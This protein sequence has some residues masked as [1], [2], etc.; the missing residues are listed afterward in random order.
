MTIKTSWDS[1]WESWIRWLAIGCLIVGIGLRFWQLDRSVFWYDEVATAIR[2]S[3]HRLEAFMAQ[4]F[5]GQLVSLADLAT[6]WQSDGMSWHDTWQALTSHPEHPPLYFLLTRWWMDCFGSSANSLRSLAA[7]LSLGLFPGIYWLGWELSRSRLVGWLAIALVSLSPI[8][9]LYAR[10]ARQYSLWTVLVVLSGAA[11]LRALRLSDRDQ[12]DQRSQ[13]PKP[14][15]RLTSIQRIQTWWAVW[16]PAWWPYVLTLTLSFYT[17]LLT[18]FVAIAHGG[19]ALFLDVILFDRARPGRRVGSIVLSGAIATM[20]FI[21]WLIVLITGWEAARDFTS[22][23]TDYKEPRKQV[24]Q[25][26]ADQIARGFIQLVPDRPPELAWPSLLVTSLAVLVLGL[27]VWRCSLRVWGFVL[28]LA[29]VASGCLV[30]PDAI[31]GA[32]RTLAT[33]Y[34]MPTFLGLQVAIALLLGQA[35]AG[36]RDWR[37][38]GLV[39]VVALLTIG[40][41]TSARLSQAPSLWMTKMISTGLPPIAER[42]NQSP[43]PVIIADA[44][45]YHAG[46]TAALAR[47]LRPP[48]Q[49]YLVPDFDRLSP[50]AVAQMAAQVTDRQHRFSD[51]YALNLS[52]KAR[53]QIKGQLKWAIETIPSDSQAWLDRLDPA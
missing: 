7:V 48:A 14:G 12:P 6:Y 2:A 53:K 46:N 35:L 3:G 40:G 8:H 21:P 36:R 15:D 32:L 37:W 18:L 47:W 25:R 30:V 45:I 4:E 17:A 39:A 5:T 34:W 16:W 20:A 26:F 38:L 33:R 29:L 10:E 19:Y 51:I 9:V 41:V 49:F 28:C 11:L 43:R 44:A 1:R 13:D 50:A 42:I 31:D 52:T 22:W 23:T 24:W 27:V